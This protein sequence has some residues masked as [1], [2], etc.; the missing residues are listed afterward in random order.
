[1]NSYGIE[2]IDAPQVILLD[3]FIESF[4]DVIKGLHHF[5]ITAFHAFIRVYQK[6]VAFQNQMKSLFSELD[7]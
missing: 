4:S 5:T 3:I 2:V 1:M 6:C 7:R